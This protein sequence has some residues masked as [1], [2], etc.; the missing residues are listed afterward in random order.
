MIE[1]IEKIVENACKKKENVFGYG[2]WIYHISS[3]I[4]YSKLLAKKLNA[5]TEIVVISAL[6]HDYT[7][8]LG[9]GD[10]KEHHITGAKEAEKLLKKF[11]YPKEKIEKVKHCI[12]THRGSTNLKRETIEA[13]IVASADA[14]AHFDNVAPLFH[15]VYAERKME[16]DKGKEWLMAKFKRSWNKLLPEA[17]DMV[18]DKYEAI[19]VLF[20]R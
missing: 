16:I 15:M 17:R 13:E 8:V 9:K 4:K 14:M 12:L 20:R 6:L 1:E 5:D 11:N 7:S 18:K 10:F 3:V 19:K 2:A